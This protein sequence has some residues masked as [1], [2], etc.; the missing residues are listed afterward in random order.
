MSTVNVLSCDDLRAITGYQ[1]PAD[2]ERCLS[3]QGIRVFRGRLGP[4]TT[5]DLVNQAGGLRPA[6]N[7]ETYDPDTLL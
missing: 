1:R 5:L 3:E 6:N 2:I 4:W 7:D